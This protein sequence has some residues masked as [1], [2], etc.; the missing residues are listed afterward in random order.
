[1]QT[2]TTDYIRAALKAEERSN[3]YAEQWMKWLVLGSAGAIALLLTFSGNLCDPQYA[4]RQ[5]LPAY[6]G[7]VVSLATAAISFM[8]RASQEMSFAEHLAASHNRE[9]LRNAAGVLPTVFSSPSSIAERANKQKEEIVHKL[10]THHLQA[11][12]SWSWVK[13]W[14][15]ATRILLAASAICFIIAVAWP[16]IHVAFGGALS[17]TQCASKK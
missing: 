12:H 13:R 1:M 10:N 15:G 5:L 14:R 2:D 6:L 3:A 7:F 4:L 17:S 11:E 16:G 9:Q 8:T